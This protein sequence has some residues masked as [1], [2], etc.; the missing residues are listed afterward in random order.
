MTTHSHSLRG[1]ADEG[2]GERPDPR[3]VAVAY[4]GL[5]GVALA[6][7]F[8]AAVSLNWILIAATSFAL[9]GLLHTGRAYLELSRQRRVADDWLRLV[10]TCASTS[11]YAWRAEELTSGRERR[12]LARSLRRVV[13]EV[14]GRLLPGGVPINRSG[15]RPHVSDL[16]RLA[17]E[18]EDTL[19]SATPA[20]ILLV[21]EL[22]TN[23]KSPLYARDRASELPQAI[24]TILATL[25]AV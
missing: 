7:G 22:L 19:N 17:V 24:S 3:S 11:R 21:H 10:T 23:P 12:A 14:N 20:G 6:V 15:L 18:L 5:V 4:V 1:R 9:A 16:C 2:L 13:G 8:A 25:R